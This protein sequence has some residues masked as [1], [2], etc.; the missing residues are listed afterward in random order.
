MVRRLARTITAALILSALP[1]APPAL[2]GV[3]EGQ[4]AAGPSGIDTVEAERIA[5]SNRIDTAIA[6]SRAGW[7][8]SQSAVLATAGAFPDALVGGP[9]AARLGA[10]LLLT[11]ADALPNAVGDELER[12]GV[13]RVY[14]LGGPEAIS[15]AVARSVQDLA[16]RPAVHRI[17]GRDRYA[18]AA[19][20]ATAAADDA[21]TVVLAAGADFPDALAGSSLP[22]GAERSPVLLVTR[23]RLPA[24]TAELLATLRPRH[25]V[26]VGGS[27]A[28]SPAVASA[29]ARAAGGARI[30][31]LA[32]PH[33]YATATAVLEEALGRVGDEQR[34]LIVATGAAFPDA[35][36]AGALAGRLDGLVALTPRFRLDDG[37]D[38]L[39]RA[40]RHRFGR[41]IVLGGEAAVDRDVL[42]ELAAADAGTPRPPAALQVHGTAAGFRGTARP[43]PQAVVEEM[44]GVSWRE[45]CPVGLDDLALLSLVHRGFDGRRVD[46]ELV[47]ARA[48]AVDVLIAFG[49][50]YDAG[51][52]IQRMERIDAFGGDDDA[53]MAANNTSAFSCRRVAGSSSWSEHAYGAA[54][55]VN[56]VQNPYVRDGTVAPDAGRQFLD[57]RDHRAG[58]V[59]TGGPLVEAF[60]ALGWGWGGDW[61]SAKDY[62]HFSRSGR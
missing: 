34:P 26:V 25:L 7:D 55:D 4:R 53:S 24:P 10:P 45:G 17:S 15:E 58:M 42:A 35:L 41:V 62:Q 16:S 5:G 9:V 14:L 3:P 47:V 52:P 33:R 23:D 44:R 49:R 18:T 59:R 31:R 19:A 22:S 32:G 38:A 36:A 61:S 43:L 30:K 29:A 40:Q 56:P 37:M 46:G 1:T 57:R 50:A 12:L 54:I 21:D 20:A 8:R 60:R 13:E 28:L 6:A 39:L 2:A 11:S 27:A 48:V 51:F